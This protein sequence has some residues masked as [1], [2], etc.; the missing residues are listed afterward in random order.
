MSET[1]HTPDPWEV[2]IDDN[3][4]EASTIRAGGAII[5]SVYGASDFPCLESNERQMVAEAQVA[6][7]FLIGAAPKMLAAL[8]EVIGV[9]EMQ[10]VD[11]DFRVYELVKSAIA[12]AEV[13]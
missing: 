4:M 13:K 10:G 9:Y 1:K 11:D 6:N 2:E 12:K 5:A 8:K 7:A 3:G